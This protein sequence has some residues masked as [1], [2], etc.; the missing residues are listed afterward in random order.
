MIID[1]ATIEAVR[2]FEGI[3]LV[4]SDYV[5]LKKRGKNFLGL[6]PFHAEKSPSFTVS[7][8]KKL[9]HCFGCHESGDLI[10]FLMKIDSLSFKEAIERI[11][12]RAG[13]E[14]IY[15]E[16]TAKSP[17]EEKRREDILD[18][19]LMAKTYY[20][21]ALD[22]ATEVQKYV[23]ERGISVENAQLFN[24]GF[25]PQ[26]NVL[27]KRLKDKGY[28]DDLLEASGLFYPLETG[29]IKHRF[30]GRLIIPIMD[31]LGRTVA[32]GG[33]ILENNKN[34][35]K[36][37]NSPETSVFNKSYQLY[38]LDKAKNSIR[39]ENQAIIMEGYMDVL[40]AH[41]YG[42]T[43]AV[44][45]MGT[46]LTQQQIQLINRFSHKAALCF[47]S[48]SAGQEA[49]VR[50]IE[51]LKQKGFGVTVISLDSKD[52]AD[53]LQSEG[54]DAFK[55]C[56][57][58]ADYYLDYLADKWIAE[59][60]I[61]NIH[62]VATLINNLVPFIKLEK[63][64]VLQTHFVTNLAS[65]LKVN[66][67]LILAKLQNSGYIRATKKYT[68]AFKNK[69]KYVKAEEL[70]IYACASNLA[71]RSFLADEISDGIF[72]DDKHKSLFET[73]LDKSKVDHELL[74]E[75]EEEDRQLLSRILVEF[76]QKQYRVSD[77]ECQQ[78]LVIL[79][80]RQVKDEIERIKDQLSQPEALPEE[81][82][83]RLL[84]RLSQL[85]N[86]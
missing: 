28:S 58:K 29:G 82:E 73:M 75:Y 65:K 72:Q 57:E 7:P 70:L 26:N 83:T 39:K 18:I 17:E 85:M 30:A 14:V 33:R 1:T 41:Q 16:G 21:E 62:E 5:Q 32:F 86:A 4:I 68:P 76:D 78:C 53:V 40:M 59:T 45:S 9:F 31:H 10:A 34:M 3:D 64:N 2:A 50:S 19:L 12:E 49:T 71:Q 60:D 44:G 61:E 56:I 43:N 84:Q 23:Q 55:E 8:D 77:E 38:G 52:P 51:G 11:A 48:D 25:A 47:D 36:Y 69:T 46:A 22:E 67:D 66:R 13:I 37:I 54:V 81:E 6:C 35:A 20:I 80:E 79:K 15:K 63:D 42:I 27:E 24:L 74:A